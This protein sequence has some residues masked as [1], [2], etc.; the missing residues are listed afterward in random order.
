MSIHDTHKEATK[1]IVVDGY[2][3]FFEIDVNILQKDKF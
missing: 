1:K 3:S 2:R